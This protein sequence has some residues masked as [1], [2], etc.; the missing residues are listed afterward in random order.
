MAKKINACQKLPEIFRRHKISLEEINARIQ[1]FSSI[2]I[3]W[4]ELKDTL[5]PGRSYYHKDTPIIMQLIRRM[6]LENGAHPDEIDTSFSYFN[7]QPMTP[8]E[9]IGKYAYRWRDLADQIS[10]ELGI[11]VSHPS[12]TRTM[13]PCD[14]YLHSR[15]DD[16]VKVIV[17]ML[18]ERGCPVDLIEQIIYRKHLS[19]KG[20]IEMLPKKALEYFKLSKQPFVDDLDDEDSLFWTQSHKDAFE[21]IM[22]AATVKA[23][24]YIIGNTGC[25]KTTLKMAVLQRLKRDYKE[26]KVINYEEPENERLAMHDIYTIMLDRL[27]VKRQPASTAQKLGLI[28]ERLE[29]QY[30]KEEITTFVTIDEAQRLSWKTIAGLKMLYDTYYGFK[31]IIGIALIG[32]YELRNNIEGDNRLESSAM[33]L[34]PVEIKG[35][36]DY[37]VPYLEKKLKHA[38]ATGEIFTRDAL[39]AIAHKNRTMK[40]A[41]KIASI[42]MMRAFEM[43]RKPVQQ[44]DVLYIR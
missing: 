16:I 6:F 25:G 42:A 4:Y 8:A 9:L 12:L 26:I 24:I 11:S 30:E 19:M 22:L 33:R 15:H 21:Q 44:Q 18:I 1:S 37:T 14:N 38:G 40:E 20:G 31:R 7:R 29:R 13:N 39:L 10:R 2:T 41:N 17:Q 35:L 36:G 3:S 27:G 23:F 28:K 43:Q 5:A 34:S 32:T